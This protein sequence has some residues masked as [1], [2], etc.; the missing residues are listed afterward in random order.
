SPSRDV[1]EI[2]E[3][4][5]GKIDRGPNAEDRGLVQK[6]I[7]KLKLSRSASMYPKRGLGGLS[8][9][10]KFTEGRNDRGPKTEDRGLGQKQII[11]SQLSRIAAGWSPPGEKSSPKSQSRDILGIRDLTEVN[12]INTS[13]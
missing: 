2:R 1:L 12:D 8:N 5:E 9:S 10:R 13:K 4:A 7:S 6:Q 3:S 11:K